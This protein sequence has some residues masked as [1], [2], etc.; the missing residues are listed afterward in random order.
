MPA[1]RGASAD[2][3]LQFSLAHLTLLNCAPPELTEIAARAGYDFVSLRPIAMGNPGEPMY[4]LAT[5]AQ[6]L[7]RTR[8]AL[9][10]TGV[11]CWTSS[12]RA[13]LRMPMCRSYRPALECAAELGARHVLTS[14][15]CEGRDYVLE[16]FTRLCEIAAPLGLTVDFEAVTFTPFRPS[17]RR[18][19]WSPRPASNAGICID[20]LHFDRAGNRAEDLEGLPSS[21][22]HYAQ[23]CDGPE[24]YSRE[25]E[26]LKYVAREAP[27]VRRRRRHRRAGHPRPAAAH[28][29][30]HRTAQCAAPGRTRPRAVRPPLPGHRQGLSREARAAGALESGRLA[31]PPRGG[32]ASL[33]QGDTMTDQ[34]HGSGVPAAFPRAGD[35]TPMAGGLL[36]RRGFGQLLGMQAAVVSVAALPAAVAVAADG[37]GMPAA[38]AGAAN[39]TAA[40]TDKALSRGAFVAPIV[41][42]FDWVHSS[43]YVDSYKPVQPTF[44]DVT[45]GVTPFARQ[46]EIALEEG[47]VSNAEGFFHPDRP[48]TD[49]EAVD[50]CTRAFGVAPATRG[51][52]AAPLSAAAAQAML[53]GLVSPWPRR[54]RSCPSPA[55][56]RHAATCASRRRRRARP[57]ATRSHP[58][59]ASPPI[60]AAPP[61]LV[62][63]FI[64]D[65]VLK[66][67]N[68]PNSTTDYR[69]YRMKAVA[70]KAGLATSAV[71]EF[72][73]NIV[74]PRSGEFQAKLVAPARPPRPGCGR[75]TTRRKSCS[76][77]STTSRARR[78]DCVRRGEYSYKS[79]NLKAFVDTLATRPYDDLSA[80]ATRTMPSRSSTSRRPASGCMCRR[81][82]RPR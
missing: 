6:L 71:R 33:R 61:G 7:R 23:I 75:S 29:L 77:M 36:S 76:P 3:P 52:P 59:A 65:G 25:T 56:P 80:T 46:I 41:D 64:A 9:A 24:Q 73:W 2:S 34:N 27:A 13:S 49:G 15:W 79:A 44:A 51:A 20:T 70:L 18:R 81:R 31:P 66:L 69:L 30:L 43:Q 37:S 78:G 82:R 17:R 74:R 72:T 16:Q 50:I 39:A 67:V 45:L 10:A 11:R 14:A 5:D 62:Y 1:L 54:L 60:R 58:T 22:F 68:P 26:Q 47:L 28:T 19:T 12:W 32:G 55:A 63:D 21:W 53:R 35:A 57:S 8:A 48:M 38:G 42:H 40:N 4:P